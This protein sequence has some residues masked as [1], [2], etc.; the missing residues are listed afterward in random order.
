MKKIGREVCFLHTS[1]EVSRNGEGAFARLN[2]GRIMY[3]YTEYAGQG[4][5]DGDP[6]HITAI[7]SNDEGETWGGKRILVDRNPEDKNIMSVSFL[8]LKDGKLAMFFLRK[9]G[10]DCRLNMVTSEDEGE[11]WSEATVCCAPGFHVVNNDRV[12]RLQNGEIIFPANVHN[13]PNNR[14]V[15]QQCYYVSAD[16]GKTWSMRGGLVKHPFP[17]TSSGLQEGGLYQYDSGLLWGWARTRSG[18]QFMMFSK[19]NGENWTT[20]CG[21]EVFTGPC[22]PLQVKRVG[23]YTVAIYNPKPQYFGWKEVKPLQVSTLRNRSPFLCLV[24]RDGAKSFN[25]A[26]LLEDDPANDYC[27]PA[28]L[29]GEDYFLVAYYH[30]G[31]T[32][33]C[34][35]N[36]KIL[37]V[38]YSELEGGWENPLVRPPFVFEG[39]EYYI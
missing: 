33:V 14:K 37:K 17:N 26:Y 15:S 32:G 6:A 7:F 8:R 22:A 16:E 21:S 27:Y 24:S 19:D 25:E 5:G 1:E 11:T 4:Y 39:T 9:T 36:C 23:P 28:I 10:P 3:A 30:S 12:V 20:P 35:S 29:E 38:M 34:L 2:D 31:D 18:S 13:D